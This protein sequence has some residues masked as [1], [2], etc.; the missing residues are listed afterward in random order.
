LIPSIKRS[1]IDYA[2]LE[3]VIYCVT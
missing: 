3:T 1:L 2:K